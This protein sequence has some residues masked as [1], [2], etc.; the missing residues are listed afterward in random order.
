[1]VTE[2]KI[3]TA[4]FLRIFLRSFFLQSV[5]NY[6]SLLSIGFSYALIPVLNKLYRTKEEKI[7]FLNRHLNF[8]NAHPYF[9]SFALGAITRIEEDITSG[10]GDPVQVE[11]LKNAMMGPLGA[12][13]DQMFWGTIKP[14]AILLGVIAVLI[15][16]N[17]ITFLYIFVFLLLIYNVPHLYIRYNGI[18]EGYN[19]GFEVYKLLSVSR[20]KKYQYFYVA[21]GSLGLGFIISYSFL[22]YEMSNLFHALA[23]LFAIVIAYNFYR[24]KRSFYRNAGFTLLAAV[25]FGIIVENL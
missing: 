17:I 11:R 24:I 20:Y 25:V 6:Q 10:E 21:L 4:Q 1:M 13:G 3:G 9:A 23:F 2:R 14:A 15:T 19:Q 7:Q 18:K 12:L 22:V 8:F 5:W 16:Q